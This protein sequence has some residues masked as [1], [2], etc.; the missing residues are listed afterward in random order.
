[1]QMF[2]SNKRTLSLHDNNH[3]PC[4][5]VATMERHMRQKHF[6]QRLLRKSCRRRREG[7]QLPIVHV[8]TA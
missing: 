1:M 7:M 5:L 4:P 2:G 3:K 6:R 8:Q